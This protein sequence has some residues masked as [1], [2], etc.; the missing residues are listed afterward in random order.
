MKKFSF[1]C[2]VLF[3]FSAISFATPIAVGSGQNTA[4]VRIEW[5]DGYVAEFLVSFDGGMTGMGLLNTITAETTLVVTKTSY[6]DDEFVD[7]FS[8]NSHSNI[9]YNFG[10]NWWHYYNKDAGQTDWT[11]S[12]VGASDRVVSNGNWDGWS[13]GHEI[14]EPTTIAILSL[15]SV[16][17]VRKRK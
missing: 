8:F 1:V 2:C 15:G 13:Y 14:P 11:A 9:G 4:G 12:F 6:G 10:E 5:S 3:L 16:L 17:L 7:G